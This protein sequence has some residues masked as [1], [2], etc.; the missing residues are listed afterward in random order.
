M[1]TQIPIP[2]HFNP[3]KVGEIWRVPYQKIAAEAETYAVQ[4][5]IQPSAL[6]KNRVCLLLIDVQNTFCIPDFELFVGGQ[7][8]TGAVEDNQRLCAFIYRNLGVITKIIPTLDTHT[9]MQIFHPIFWINTQ[10]E[11][12]TPAATNITVT[13][14]E[15]G[16]WQ[17]NPAV[18]NS[19]TNGDYDLLGKQ[20]F[21]YV[22][23]LSQ[24][25][26]YPLT[27]WPYHS[28]LGGIGHALVA[29]VEEAVFFHSIVR[30][31][32]TQFELKGE[33]P[34]TENYSILRP[35]VLTGFN[36]QP[37]GQKNTSLIQQL[38]EYDAVIIA[39]QAKSHCVAW[40]IDD[41]FTEIQQ[42]DST[43]TRKIYLL[44]DCT[45]PVVVPGVVDYTEQANNI[46]ARFAAAGMHIIQSTQELVIG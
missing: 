42:V 25:G 44:E 37:I 3:A 11:H 21:Y 40:T 45:S 43:L 10:G 32:Q 31:S 7:T 28:M 22:Q 2:P 20:A 24:N 5:Q 16:I 30:K 39:G 18:A 13:D 1:N 15:K 26:K 12:P 14:I 17:V 35:E 38:L 27:V 19:I 36:G 8:G 34:L 4:Q 29:S 6:D 41:L 46:F 33:N 23:Q 9:T